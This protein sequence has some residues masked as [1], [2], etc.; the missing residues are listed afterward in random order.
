MSATPVAN[1]RIKSLVERA[2]RLI[3]EKAEITA[4]LALVFAEAKGEG[5]DTAILKK[6]IARRAKDTAQRQ[7]ED[8]LLDL[9]ASAI[10]EPS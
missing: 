4:D 9:Y 7:E 10:G 3:A 8:A 1:A 2:E 5:F 6:L